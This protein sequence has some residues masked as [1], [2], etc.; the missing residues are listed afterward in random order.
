MTF[1]LGH[2]PL[3][4]ALLAAEAVFA[5][6][7]ANADITLVSAGR[8]VA[9]HA[10][11]Q[12][13]GLYV[14]A[15]E[16]F[17][18]LGGQ[19]T[20]DAVQKAL[21]VELAG[22]HWLFQLFSQFVGVDGD[23]HNLMYP[24]RYED[25]SILVPMASLAPILDFAHP[26]R[27]AWNAESATLVVETERHNIVDYR[28]E[29]KKNGLL[30][31][32]ALTRPLKFEA[33]RSE[34]NWLNFTIEEGRFAPEKFRRPTRS[35]LVAEVTAHQFDNSAQLS[36]RLARNLGPFITRVATSPDRIQ[37]LFEDST[38]F[39]QYPTPENAPVSSTPDPIDVIVIDPGHGGPD[40]GAIG[41]E[42]GTLEKDVVLEIGRYLR[43]LI[44]DDPRL[45]A[46]MTREDDRFVP[47][48]ERA[49][50][51]NEAG[52]DLFVSIHAN[53]A[54]K[55]TARGSQTF[56]LA[57]A[58]NDEARAIAQME[59]SSLRFEEERLA[60][61]SAVNFILL[62][63]I[64]TEFQRESA[65]LADFI[66]QRLEKKLD[67]PSRG[68]DQAGFVVLNKVYMPAVLVESAFISN[69]KEEK[70]LR[71]SGF[72]KNIAKAVYES[73]KQFKDRY[74]PVY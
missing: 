30:V 11:T 5:A 34:G 60:D 62:D 71:K 31:E 26:R 65:D 55:S 8:R 37:V 51:A 38:F 73:I 36:F 12:K 24:V 19:V 21:S 59:N 74:D 68:V 67:I 70:L 66:Q 14:S 54:R 10:E 2:L 15:V 46:I 41:R 48:E 3:C 58:K 17:E 4:L 50:I 72:Q 63:M 29:E 23:A 44:N 39:M 40:E 49:R 45:R 53:A 57:Q 56:F 64:Q 20:W 6:P 69:E 9:I 1:R 52:A 32:V 22:H 25:G 7:R 18:A 28:I 16:L 27:V 47:L 61:T 42:D 35:P 13:T 43:E 33:F